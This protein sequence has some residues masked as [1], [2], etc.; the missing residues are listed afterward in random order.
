MN[1]EWLPFIGILGGSFVLGFTLMFLW[2]LRT[3]KTAVS[4]E[5]AVLKERLEARDQKCVELRVRFEE[6]QQRNQTLISEN[7][8]LSKECSELKLKVEE[9]KKLSREK[10][11][12]LEEAEKKFKDVFKSLSS[13]ILKDNNQLFLDFA[14]NTLR[15]QQDQAKNDLDKKQTAIEDLVR[16]LKD[17]LGKVDQRIFDLE[18]ARVGAY[19]S[20]QQQVRLLSDTQTQLR[21]ETSNLVRALRSPVVRGRW[22]EIQLKRVVEMAGMVDHCDFFEQE[23][24]QTDT[25]RLRPDLLVRLPGQKNI[26][27][28]AKAPLSSYLEAVES[29]DD[30]VKGEKLKLHAQAIRKHMSDLSRKSYWDQFQPAPE[31]VV[32]FLPGEMFFSSALEQDPG[33]IEVG[34]EQQVILATPT[35]LIALLRSVAYGWRQEKLTENAKQIGKLGRELYKRMADM[36]ANVSRLGKNLGNAVEA[37]NRTVGSMETRVLVSARKFQDLE[38]APDGVEIPELSA[39]E[40]LPRPPS[41]GIRSERETSVSTRMDGDP[42]LSNNQPKLV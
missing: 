34:V 19:E 32:L 37:Y 16:P 20:L 14:Q 7:L 39:V 27:V 28:D 11:S 31:F 35:T 15:R 10:L 29:E 24:A 5:I 8:S 1:L 17:S 30:S 23:T 33:L 12:T 2:S 40:Q 25:G 18:K 26:V 4:T 42:P 21:S 38:S 3:R 22:G 13:D 6:E 36:T 9:E 41:E